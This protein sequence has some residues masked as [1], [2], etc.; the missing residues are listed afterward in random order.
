MTHFYLFALLYI[1][2]CH[3]ASNTNM[4]YF[5][6][7]CYRSFTTLKGLKSHCSAKRHYPPEC[8]Q[9]NRQFV[10]D[11]ALQQVSCP[12]CILF[13]L[14][15][16]LI[17]DPSIHLESTDRIRLTTGTYEGTLT[18]NLTTA[19]NAIGRSQTRRPSIITPEPPTT[20][21][22][23]KAGRIESVFCKTLHVRFVHPISNLPLPL[24]SISNQAVMVS[25]VTK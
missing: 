1:F 23:L 21:I 10:N 11:H 6:T 4:P 13:V 9:C 3:G 7:S 16:Q 12:V 24:H 5:C 14:F 18:T 17:C 2:A 8:R 15:N 20:M 19:L 22:T 25:P